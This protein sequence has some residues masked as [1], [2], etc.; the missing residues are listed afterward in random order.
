LQCR[1]EVL[2]VSTQAGGR[3][4]GGRRSRS[5]E[6]R[7]SRRRHRQL[8]IEQVATGKRLADV[9]LRGGDAEIVERELPEHGTGLRF[10]HDSQLQLELRSPELDPLSMWLRAPA[11]AS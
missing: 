4:L 5:R 3:D 2:D 6:R 1:K 8:D 11:T 7:R 10:E 9:V